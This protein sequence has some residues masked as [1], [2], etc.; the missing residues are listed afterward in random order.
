MDK[1]PSIGRDL[2]SDPRS[3][4]KKLGMVVISVISVFLLGEEWRLENQ[5]AGDVVGDAE[6]K[7]G[8][9]TSVVL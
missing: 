6:N 7:E 8:L 3:L 4:C 1:T 9:I 5:L 2:S